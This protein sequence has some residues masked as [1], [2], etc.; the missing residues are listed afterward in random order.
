MAQIKTVKRLLVGFLV[1][2]RVY[3]YGDH[4]YAYG[5]CVYAYEAWVVCMHMGIMCMHMEV[6]CMHMRRGLSVC[7]WTV[8]ACV[9]I[10]NN[11]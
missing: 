10:W 7:I 11:E 3:A 9:C 4:V 1:V 5:G 8:Y 6:V 2:A